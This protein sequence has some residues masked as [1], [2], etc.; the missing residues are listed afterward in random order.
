MEKVSDNMFPAAGMALFQFVAMWLVMVAM[1]GLAAALTFRRGLIMRMFGIDCVTRAGA[2]AS[3]LRMLWRSM[4]FNAPVLMAPIMLAFVYP[5]VPDMTAAALPI[6]GLVLALACWSCLL[7]RRGL[8]DR[9]AGTFP[10]P[11]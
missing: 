3:R 10:V 9:L 1:P 4:L 7:P 8:S 5:L 2:P 11:K 6:I